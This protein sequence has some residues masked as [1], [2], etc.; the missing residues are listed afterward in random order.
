MLKLP[1]ILWGIGL[2]LWGLGGILS[3]WRE[4]ILLSHPSQPDS[5]AVSFPIPWGSIALIVVGLSL[6]S[7]SLFFFGFDFGTAS[8]AKRP[9]DLQK[10]DVA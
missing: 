8:T 7:L 3:Q 2:I 1:A 4:R 10:K 5:Y 9:A 6:L